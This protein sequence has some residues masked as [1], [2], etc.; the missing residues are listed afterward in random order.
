M[1]PI[2]CLLSVLIFGAVFSQTLLGP[3]PYLCSND[4]P[5]VGM[6][7]SQGYFH[8]EDFEDHLFNAPGVTFNG[9]RLSSSFGVS[10]IDSVDCDDG[11][12]NNCGRGDAWWNN[13][14]PGH[15]ID[16]DRTVLGNWPNHVGLVWTDGAGTITF[17]AFDQDLS[18]IG[19]LTGNHADA[20][21]NCG[22]AEDRFY[23][24]IYGDGVT[25]GIRRIIL[26]NTSG[27]IEMD[28]LQYGYV[29][30]CPGADGDVNGDGCVD[31]TDLARVL[32]MFGATGELDEDLNCDGIVDDT[33]L[34]IV[35]TQFGTGC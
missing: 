4:S 3:A 2:A 33:D 35:L 34:A 31:D 13:G 14:N 12:V 21:F 25:T 19:R 6:D 28:H 30:A 16:F 29:P 24:A 8:F 26:R 10:L 11:S 23:G 15:I 20:N 7:F 18:E 9:G 5:F 22:T 27:G 32:T 1:K 17:I